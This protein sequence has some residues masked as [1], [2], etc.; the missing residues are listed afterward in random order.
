MRA[1]PLAPSYDGFNYLNETYSYGEWPYDA[2][3]NTY[4][5]YKHAWPAPI[6]MIQKIAVYFFNVDDTPI[7][8]TRIEIFEENL[9]EIIQKPSWMP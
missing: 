2:A 1:A 3:Y 7:D 4:I 5:I 8:P 6:D 9:L